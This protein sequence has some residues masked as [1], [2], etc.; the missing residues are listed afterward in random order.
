V[1]IVIRD[2]Q[3]EK[4]VFVWIG[5]SGCGRSASEEMQQQHH[6]S[7]YQHDVNKAAGNVKGQE[8]KQP[9]NNQDRSNYSKHVSNSF[10]L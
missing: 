7:D 6:Y 9:K 1:R 3:T 5:I 4:R 8:P 2:L 10:Y